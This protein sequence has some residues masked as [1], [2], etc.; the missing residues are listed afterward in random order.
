MSV[1]DPL[2]EEG[3]SGQT[4]FPCLLFICSFLLLVYC[5]VSLCF[6]LNLRIECMKVA[7]MEKDLVDWAFQLTKA[8]MQK[9]YVVYV[10]EN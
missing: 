9:L 7:N 5:H 6:S 2:T 3:S 8:N 1:K 10:F 4:I